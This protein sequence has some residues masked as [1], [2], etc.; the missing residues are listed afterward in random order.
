MVEFDSPFCLENCC[1]VSSR[2]QGL[3]KP[4]DTSKTFDLPLAPDSISNPVELSSID[5]SLSDSISLGSMQADVYPF[6]EVSPVSDITV[7]PDILSNFSLLFSKD[8]NPILTHRPGIF[9]SQTNSL[10]CREDYKATSESFNFQ[11]ILTSIE[12]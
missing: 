2:I 4:P 12:S 5:C 1:V 7:P 9:N 11:R 3:G 6:V 10:S 8:Q